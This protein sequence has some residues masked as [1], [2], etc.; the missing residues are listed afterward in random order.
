MSDGV[1]IAGGG[2][3]GQRCAEALRQGGYEGPVRI[4]CGERTAPYD[5]PPLSKKFLAGEHELADIAL[6]P[7]EWHTDKGVELLLGDPA[8][9]L[10]PDRR[11]LVLASGRE[12]P[13]DTLVVATGSRARALPDVEA[14][15]NV[16][17]LRTHLDAERLRY[18][19]QPGTRLAVLGAGLIGQEVA[20]TA[21]GRGADVVLVEAAPLPLARALHPELAAW[22]CD[23]QR[24]EGVEV[25]LGA[26]VEEFVG[27]DGVLTA[28]RLADGTSVE[29]DELLIAIG[30]QPN[31]D[32]LPAPL[33]ELLE[34]PEIHAAGD[35]AGGDHWELA[36]HQ[37][38][39]VAHAILEQPPKATPLTSWWTDVHGIRIQGL[40][41]PAGADGLIY[42]GDPS[43]RSFTAVAT[44]AGTPVAALSVARPRELPRL[45]TLLTSGSDPHKEPA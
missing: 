32:W 22:L 37:G 30:V 12:V 42:D 15:T 7:A 3:A 33:A 45:R 28:L 41:D 16:H 36:A 21:S 1:V 44:R 40:G 10:D 25:L 18:A 20:A 8:A 27:S 24:E 6:R 43:E 14:Y 35:V 39:A 19:L 17:T 13:Y 26:R 11:R 34:R 2:L 5:R 4:V 38:R 23:V 31:D 29:L 9:G